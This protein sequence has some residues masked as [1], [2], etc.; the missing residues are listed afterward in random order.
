MGL[1]KS[2]VIND[3]SNAYHWGCFGTSNEILKSMQYLD[4]ETSTFGVEE[5]YKLKTSPKKESHF[6]DKGFARVFLNDNPVLGALLESSDTIVINGEGTLHDLNQ[7]TFNLLYI[8]NLAKIQLKKPVHLINTSLFPSS[9]MSQ[10][11]QASLI[12]KR[13]LSVLDSITVRDEIS[14]SI[15]DKLGL[16]VLQ[17]FDCLPRYLVRE[18]FEPAIEHNNE[19]ILG[20]G[21]GLNPEI[22]SEIIAEHMDLIGDHKLVYLT[23]ARAN[24]A[25]DDRV[26]LEK[27]NEYSIQFE[28][29]EAS[30]FSDWV[31]SINNSACLISGRFHHTIAAA[32][33]NTP[34]I[35]YK[36]ATP[37]N[38]SLCR[39]L[40]LSNVLD[41]NL[42]EDRIPFRKML[43]N[44][45]SNQ[46]PMLTEQIRKNILKLGAEN[47]VKLK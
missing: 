31:F 10:D 22:F 18:S 16:K 29:R 15:A 6:D 8:C 5:V 36:A 2:V 35:T 13:I 40:K 28:H 42:K 17:G 46:A 44:F 37:K 47:F 45:L 25:N 1:R 41:G 24:P 4:F 32:W 21:L 34:V 39:M 12:Y 3:T 14:Y 38:D 20:G 11:E 33:L 19:I 9:Y 7:S 27:L 26:F 43:V 30:S 23:G